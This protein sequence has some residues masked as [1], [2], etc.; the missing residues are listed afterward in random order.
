MGAKNKGTPFRDERKLSFCMPLSSTN[1]MQ[2]KNF[3]V[4]IQ[5]VHHLLSA[6]LVEFVGD[7]SGQRWFG[8]SKNCRPRTP[9]GD[10]SSNYKRSVVKM[11]PKFVLSK[12]RVHR[13]TQRRNFHPYTVRFLQEF[14]GNGM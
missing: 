3:S 7:F 4:L 12:S 14:N 1:D 11:T 2:L 8:Q 9:T 10:E 5:M 6:L 13:I